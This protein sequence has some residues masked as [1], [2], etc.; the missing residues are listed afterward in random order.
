[1]SGL[2]KEIYVVVAESAPGDCPIVFESENLDMDSAIAFKKRISGNYGRTEIYK[3]VKIKDN[4]IA[5]RVSDTTQAD[6]ETWWYNEGAAARQKPEEDQEEF[7]NRI[8]EIAWSN[9]AYKNNTMG[10]EEATQK[11]KEILVGI[12]QDQSEYEGN[13][14]WETSTGVSFGKKKLNEIILLVGKIFKKDEK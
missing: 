6:Y 13:G 14:W 4:I 11:V 2:P 5:G 3:A 7:I 12:D 8:T 9:G 10:L 1:M